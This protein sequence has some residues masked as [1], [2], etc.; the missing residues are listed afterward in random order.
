MSDLCTNRGGSIHKSDSFV[1]KLTA[2]LKAKIGEAALAG[3]VLHDL[4]WSAPWRDRPSHRRP[5]GEAD[6]V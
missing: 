5:K 6:S 2:W 1:F 3:E 4:Q